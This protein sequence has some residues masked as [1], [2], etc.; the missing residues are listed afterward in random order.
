[1][2]DISTSLLGVRLRNPTVLASGILGV[3]ASS[4]KRVAEAGAG[5]VTMKSIGPERR[6]GHPTPV[7]VEVTSGLLNA[8][9]LSCP[10]PDESLEELRKAVKEIK[11]PV[12]ASFYGRTV[13]E[14]GEVAERISEA[15]PA[16]IEANIS[17][18]N[19]ESEYGKPFGTDPEVTG[20]IT[21]KVKNKTRIPLIVKLTPNVLDI[22]SIAK[23]AESAG[24]DIISAI[25]S[26]GPGMAI[27]IETAKPILSNKFGGMSGSAIK[28]LA[29]RCV[30][31]IYEA[32]NIPIIGVGGI[33]TGRDAVEMMMAGATAVGVGTAVMNRDLKV[34]S[35]ICGELEGFMEEWGY[36]KI[37]EL[38]GKAHD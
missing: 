17:C 18:P 31:E 22:A 5:A 4:L 14:F 20:K 32:V 24:A 28:P 33:Q 25:N 38:R 19:M 30:Y 12:I 11:A 16:F 1:M 3:T 29:V 6:E 27:N 10:S 7:V 8:V 13:K 35:E 15:K 37:D 26:Y 36:S 2:V 9:G 23:A 21:E 34:F